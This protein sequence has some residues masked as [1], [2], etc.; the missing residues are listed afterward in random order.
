MLDS[1]IV[2]GSAKRAASKQERGVL[3]VFV[4][5]LRG[6]FQSAV[7]VQ[8]SPMSLRPFRRDTGHGG[9]LFAS[10]VISFP[11]SITLLKKRATAGCF[12]SPW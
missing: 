8:F 4:V 11:H 6:F 2:P 9:R 3:V 1:L 7:D 12:L 10:G 5:R